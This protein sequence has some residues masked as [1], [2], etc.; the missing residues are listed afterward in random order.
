MTA[1]TEEKTKV[2][3]AFTKKSQKQNFSQE[4]ECPLVIHNRRVRSVPDRELNIQGV[5]QMARQ[6]EREA[7]GIIWNKFT[8]VVVVVVLV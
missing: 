5:R 4:L 3:N 6:T 2:L 1:Y 7:V 8:L